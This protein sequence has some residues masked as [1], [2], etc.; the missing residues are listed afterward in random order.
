MYQTEIGINHPVVLLT[1]TNCC[2]SVAYLSNYFVVITKGHGSQSEEFKLR[3]RGVL[4]AEARDVQVCGCNRC[5]AVTG[6]WL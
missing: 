6:V 1:F 3:F 5:V 2:I 4:L